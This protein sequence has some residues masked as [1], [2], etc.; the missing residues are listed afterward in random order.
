MLHPTFNLIT[1]GVFHAIGITTIDRA[2]LFD[3]S[4]SCAVAVQI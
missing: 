3:K 2:G 1:V 4:N